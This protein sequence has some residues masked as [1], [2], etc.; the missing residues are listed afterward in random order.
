MGPTNVG[1]ITLESASVPYSVTLPG[2]AVAS[3]Q[4]EIRPRIG[5][6][7]QEIVYQPGRQVAVGDVLFR[8]DP[9][10]YQAAYAA[11][12][13]EVTGAQVAVDT[14][15][16]VVDRY[17]RLEGSAITTSDLQTAQSTLAQAK[18]TLLS[19]EAALQSAQLDL[20]HV[21]IKSPIA[22]LVDVSQVS[23]GAVVTANQTTALTTVTTSDPIFVDVEESSARLMRVRSRIDSGALQPGEK[24]QAKLT[25]ENGETYEGLGELITP[26]VSVSTT[27]GAVDLRFQF[28]NANREILPGQFLRVDIEIG[29][30]SAILVP[31]RATERQSDGRL[32]AFVADD[33]KAQL[34]ELTYS[35]TYENAWIVTDGVEI[36]DALV[37]DGLNNLRDGADVAT[38]PVTIN[39]Q[40][41]V[42]DVTP[43]AGE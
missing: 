39:A 1:V 29:Q 4:T 37:L 12:E 8:L 23:V 32:T 17:T 22:G 11:A 3:Q 10:S 41:V 18:A 35:G 42:E 28:D 16:A 9:G 2:R 43:A 30:Q 27:T 6:V 26:G 15:Q 13:A 7:I 20:D 34:V 21:E 19:A 5:G 25:L 31:Q 33:G 14:A 36:G 24:L 38:V 40:G